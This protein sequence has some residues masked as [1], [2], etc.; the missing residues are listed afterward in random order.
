MKV[1]KVPTDNKGA[2]E[3]TLENLAGER[4]NFREHKDSTAHQAAVLALN[5][6]LDEWV[7]VTSAIVS[8]HNPQLTLA[9]LEKPL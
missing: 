6:Q 9:T 7:N 8:W 2:L 1:V 3:Y 5:L 4:V